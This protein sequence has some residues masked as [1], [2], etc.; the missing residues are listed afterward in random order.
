M[1]KQVKSPRKIKETQNGL[2]KDKNNAINKCYVAVYELQYFL[3]A[4]F[5]LE[6]EKN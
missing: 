5:K 6:T 4:F 3:K 2:K 1:W